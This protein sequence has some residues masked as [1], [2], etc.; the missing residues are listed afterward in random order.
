MTRD[1]GCVRAVAKGVRKTNSRFG[2]RLEPFTHVDV[3]LHHGRN[4]DTVTQ[5]EVRDAFGT[6][7]AQ[8][9]A[10]YT[11]GG[12]MVEAAARLTDHE[13]EPAPDQFVLLLGAL[14]S[15]ARG[16]HAAGLTLDAYLLRAVA[17]AGYSPALD[18]CARCA[19]TDSLVGF[20]AAVGG[21]VCASCRPPGSQPVTPA[22]IAVMTALLHAD[23]ATADAA[24][25]ELQ[26]EVSMLTGAFAQ[27]HL[28]AGL[29]SLRVIAQERPR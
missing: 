1:H 19:A 26:R 12:A 9:Y 21:V 13:Q 20:A 16:E 17:I 5:V 3:V 15:L 23:W 25:E 27:Y 2:A 22:A 8:D 14:R 24:D 28:E 7:L 11:A 4:L 18:S 29:R 10:R 6:Q